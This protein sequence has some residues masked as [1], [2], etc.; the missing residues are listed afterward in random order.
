MALDSQ[1]GSQGRFLSSLTTLDLDVGL[2][3]EPCCLLEDQE[4][5]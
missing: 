2:P 4:A 5:L 1:H 3:C